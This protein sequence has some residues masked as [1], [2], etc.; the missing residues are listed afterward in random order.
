[1]MAQKITLLAGEGEGAYVSN[2]TNLVVQ[3]KKLLFLASL[4]LINRKLI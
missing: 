1:M 3:C 4:S 2:A